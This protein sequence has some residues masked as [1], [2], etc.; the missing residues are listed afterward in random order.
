[1]ALPH[2]EW[3]SVVTRNC[4]RRS[5]SSA[6]CATATCCRTWRH[7]MAVSVCQSKM[8]AVQLVNETSCAR[9]CPESPP[10]LTT[11]TSRC[12]NLYI[13]SKLETGS[14]KLLSKEFSSEYVEASNIYLSPLGHLWH[15]CLKIDDKIGNE[16]QF[17]LRRKDL[18]RAVQ[19][20]FD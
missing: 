17:Q 12:S 6:S 20:F 14:S 15:K 4:R 13:T 18:S 9:S 1:M 2:G 10:S 8:F 19:R 11:I 7:H 16:T 5:T 3:H